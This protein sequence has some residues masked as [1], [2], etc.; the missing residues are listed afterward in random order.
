M[1][2]FQTVEKLLNSGVKAST[3][4]QKLRKDKNFAK[5]MAKAIGYGY[6]PDMI[7]DKIMS[8]G[9]RQVEAG[10]TP[11]MR[12]SQERGGIV[13][14]QFAEKS[15][16][17]VKGA[18][19]LAGTALAA[20]QIPKAL[21]AVASG[22]GATQAP[23]QQTQAMQSTSTS[24]PQQGPAQ[25]GMSTKPIPAARR[26]QT[27]ATATSGAA[28]PLG[29]PGGLTP[30]QTKVAGMPSAPRVIPSGQT[31]ALP[32]SNEDE[33][34]AVAETMTPEEIAQADDMIAKAQRLPTKEEMQ[35]TE[36]SPK[37][38][39]ERFLQDFPQL[40]DYVRK[41]LKQG[42]SPSAIY[43]L[44]KSAKAFAGLVERYESGGESYFTRIR[45][46]VDE[47]SGG[48]RQKREPKDL[49]G[50]AMKTQAKQSADD[51]ELKAFLSAVEGFRR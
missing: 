11:E 44:L 34:E 46:L 36:T 5:P 28:I 14:P 35:T 27:T 15:K 3:I 29:P 26:L 7:V 40:D 18:A 19:K 4:L 31:I 21:G 6:T 22:L 38:E 16:R 23:V 42:K 20:T 43:A 24:Q 9:Q 25:I 49:L 8:I 48:K 33:E 41:Q 12:A 17:F 10:A 51:A 50:K 39:P 47:I 32:Q 1:S 13:Q 45:E 37:V 2:I 30:H